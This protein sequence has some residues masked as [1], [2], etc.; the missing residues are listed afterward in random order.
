[1]V[2]ET[3]GPVLTPWRDRVEAIVEAWYPGGAGGTAIARMLFGDVDPR[4]RLPAT[5]PARERDLPTAGD[6]G[7]YPGV[8]DV[9][10]Y[11]STSVFSERAAGF[12][13]RASSRAS[14]GWRSRAPAARV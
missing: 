13:R 12:S 11:S 9:V 4:G 1:M 3:A 8:D 7:C 14:T 6:Q 5:F 10:R 2:L